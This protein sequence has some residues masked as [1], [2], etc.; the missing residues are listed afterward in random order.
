MTFKFS[1]LRHQEE[2]AYLKQREKEANQFFKKMSS[3]IKLFDQNNKQL[4][5]DFDKEID[6]RKA[7]QSVTNDTNKAAEVNYNT[8]RNGDE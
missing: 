6:R 5:K 4:L 7:D 3:K 2:K 1:S 8:A